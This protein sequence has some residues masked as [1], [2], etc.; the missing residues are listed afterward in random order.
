MNY[1]SVTELLA[2]LLCYITK[3]VGVFVD[4]VLKDVIMSKNQLNTENTFC[5]L[6]WPQP[7]TVAT[8]CCK[9]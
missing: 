4:K 5:A 8:D 9:K 1:S 6:Y 7:A 2:F 3:T